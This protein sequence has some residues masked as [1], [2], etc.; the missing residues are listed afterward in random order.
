MPRGRA[1]GVTFTSPR[2]TATATSRRQLESRLTSLFGGRVAEQIIFGKEAVTTGAQS[3][4]DYATKL[5][6]SMVTSWGFSDKLG[7]LAYM[8]GPGRGIPRPLGDA[9]QAHFR[10]DAAHSSTRKCAG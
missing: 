4:I 10:R 1:L 6:R 8:R 5:A 9:S 3:D 7:P 2:T